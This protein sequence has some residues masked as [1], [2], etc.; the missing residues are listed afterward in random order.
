MVRRPDLVEQCVFQ[1]KLVARKDEFRISKRETTAKQNA[2]SEGT[3]SETI[4]S[5]IISKTQNSNPIHSVWRI[6]YLSS[7]FEFV[8]SLEFSD[9]VLSS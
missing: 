7:G 5:Q 9:L 4:S 1:P 2:E 3:K 6:V 8:S